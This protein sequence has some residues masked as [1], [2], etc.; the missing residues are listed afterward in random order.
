MEEKKVLALIR[1][2]LTFP[3]SDYP[4]FFQLFLV[5]IHAMKVFLLKTHRFSVIKISTQGLNAHQDFNY[6]S[7]YSLL[8]ILTCVSKASFVI[9][10][11]L[12]IDKLRLFSVLS[13]KMIVNIHRDSNVD[14][15]FDFE[16]NFGED[17]MGLVT[18]IPIWGF[19]IL[20]RL[21]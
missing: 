19:E 7:T 8:W 2:K 14:G 5:F 3:P 17:G 13:L 1:S 21:R 20:G 4:R 16:D 18:K 11:A 12:Q 10:P 15:G 9:K 6:V